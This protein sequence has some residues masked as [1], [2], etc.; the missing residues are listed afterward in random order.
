MM[1]G[2][3]YDASQVEE[4]YVD[5]DHCCEVRRAY[6]EGLEVV[7]HALSVSAHLLFAVGL[8]IDPDLSLKLFPHIVI[9]IVS[10]VV[11]PFNEQTPGPPFPENDEKCGPDGNHYRIEAVQG[12]VLECEEERI[13]DCDNH[14]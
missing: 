10:A 13:Y 12:T 7:A 9:L 2:G 5:D 1:S 14:C 6:Q 11:V 4:H 8:W 3:V